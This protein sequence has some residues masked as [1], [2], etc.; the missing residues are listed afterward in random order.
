MSSGFKH[1]LDPHNTVSGGGHWHLVLGVV[2]KQTSVLHKLSLSLVGL[3][4]VAA[5]SVEK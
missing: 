2:S 1:L 4:Q 5:A 3:K